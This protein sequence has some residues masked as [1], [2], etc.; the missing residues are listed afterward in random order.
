[1]SE[2]MIINCP[3]CNQKLRIQS[4]IKNLTL[5]CPSC[6]NF[7]WLGEKSKI[8]RERSTPSFFSKKIESIISQKPTLILA[9]CILIFFILYFINTENKKNHTVL[10]K[11]LRNEEKNTL[12]KKSSRWITISYSDL[13]DRNAIMR[14]GQT[15]GSALNNPSLRGAV[16]PFTDKYSYLLQ[17]SVEMIFGPDLPPHSNIADYFQI[18][19]EQPAWVALLKGGRI[20]LTTDYKNHVRVFLLGDDPKISYEK[21]YSIIRHCLSGLLPDDGSHLKTE[22][23]SYKNNYETSELELNL[24]PYVLE[25]VN[26]PLPAG[27]IPLDLVGLEDFFSNGGVLE[28]AEIDKNEGLIIY[29]KKGS[30]Q[31]LEGYDISLSDLAV[32]FRAV[33]HAGDNEAFVSLDPHQDPTKTTVNFGGFLED[34]RMGSVVLKADERFK[35]ITS[36]LDPHSFKDMRNYTRNFVPTFLTSNER[37][38]LNGINNS[39][40]NK[41][42]GT[43]FWFYPESIEIESDFDFKYA[44]IINPRFTADAERSKK[45]F[46]SLEEFERKK[47]AT[48]SPNIRESI[49]NL[50]Y[51][52]SQYEKAYQEIRELNNVARL[53]GIC[54]WLQSANPQHWLD[55]NALLSVKLPAFHTKRE[56]EQLL[57]AS[58]VSHIESDNLDEYLIKSNS[59]IV[60]ITP[61][62]DK[63]VKEYFLNSVNLAKYLCYK[64]DIDQKPR[65]F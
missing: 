7:F 50:N 55:L 62:L 27:I 15:L 21:N 1:M 9:S 19:L 52:Y 49:S 18:G 4:D 43:R 12:K 23:F 22:V 13:I 11:D 35:T 32:A 31:T 24:K 56:K 34:T 63:I 54:S 17:H 47:K 58:F 65:D 38:L 40:K 45:D 10:N 36:G 57:S 44:R 46:A 42:I 48:L 6:S 5:K 16:Q 60:F 28:G 33:F 51:N 59:S 3:H 61:I 26:F 25:A 29:A 20:F 30:K 2:R 39:D 53:I 64:S 41:W 8:T 37:E 14:N